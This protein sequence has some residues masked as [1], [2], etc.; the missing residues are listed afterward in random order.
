MQPFKNSLLILIIDHGL[1]DAI[2]LEM[3]Q[4]A[5]NKCNHM[6]KLKY[7]LLK[8]RYIPPNDPDLKPYKDVF[9]KMS[10]VNQLL[11]KGEKI[12]IPQYLQAEVTAWAHE[13]HQ[14]ISK[15]KSYLCSR[16]WF[17]GM[18]ALIANFV[19]CRIPRLASTPQTN[20]Q[21]LK[22]SPMPEGPW[23]QLT[24]D[25]KGPTASQLYFLLVID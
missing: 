15:M 23:K 7:C 1:P 14:G 18:D 17:P 4:Q 8:K 21:L 25:L 12:A 9:T 24:M 2:T 11:L 6:A 5:T 13:G 22:R 3:I 10:I 19:S 20:F 16:V